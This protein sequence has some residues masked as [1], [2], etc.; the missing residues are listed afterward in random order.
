MLDIWI[1]KET[2]MSSKP[3]PRGAVV[4]GVDGSPSSDLALDWAV[5]ECAR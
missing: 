3:V 1:S 4:V 2:D 5:A